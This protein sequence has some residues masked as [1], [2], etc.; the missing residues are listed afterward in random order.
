MQHNNAGK[1]HGSYR[2]FGGGQAQHNHDAGRVKLEIPSIVDKAVRE[3]EYNR[4]PHVFL[5]AFGAK[6]YMA[7]GRA[8]VIV[9]PDDT[10]TLDAVVLPFQPGGIGRNLM[11]RPENLGEGDHYEVISIHKCCAGVWFVREAAMGYHPRGGLRSDITSL[12]ARHY[13]PMIRDHLDD[14][15]RRGEILLHQLTAFT[16]LQFGL[17]DTTEYRQYRE[18]PL[19]I[20]HDMH[21]LVNDE[22]VA[23]RQHLEQ[24]DIAQADQLFEQFQTAAGYTMVPGTDTPVIED[25][26]QVDATNKTRV[27]RVDTIAAVVAEHSK[28][29][30][31]VVAQPVTARPAWMRPALAR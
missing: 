22:R 25:Q 20:Y 10:V 31:P 13:F 26:D 29:A 24:A 4:C 16:G 15:A 23:A 17:G 21:Q 9:H 8:L 2:P 5:R 7:V 12:P 3:A 28:T 11:L 6:G 18:L 30:G 14:N 1:R 19:G 27:Q